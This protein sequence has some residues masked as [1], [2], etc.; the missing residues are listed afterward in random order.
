MKIVVDID[1]RV[2]GDPRLTMLCARAYLYG[3]VAHNRLLMRLNRVPRLYDLRRQGLV[4]FDQEPNAG[5]YEEF[6]SAPLVIARG[7]GDCDDLCA[8]R[9]AELLETGE[10]ARL[11]I[12][13]KETAD[14]IKLYHVQVRR[15]DGTIED[16]SRICGMGRN[17]R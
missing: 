12:Y 6:A 7:W 14:D 2:T 16:P 11:R 13:C 4:E 5:K 3:Q 17:V 10:P 1:H 9:V 15:A 8:Y